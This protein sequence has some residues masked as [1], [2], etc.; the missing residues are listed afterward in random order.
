MC[1]V[2]QIGRSGT[3]A[4][5]GVGARD[6]GM[7]LSKPDAV[8]QL[9]DRSSSKRRAAAKALRL[10]RDPSASSALMAAL[11]SEVRD[12]RTWETQ[13]Q[14]VMALGESGYVPARDWLVEF[15]SSLGDPFM[16]A[17]GIGD[18]VVRLSILAGTTEDAL[19]WAMGSGRW[20]ILD[21]ALRALAMTRTVPTA[22][23][24]D[25][26]LAHLATLNAE[27]GL[28]FWAAVGA[29][30]WPGDAARHVLAEWA[31]LSRQDVT[32]AAQISLSGGYRKR[33]PL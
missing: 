30:D 33:H 13:Y 9:G 11:E 29:V 22:E 1:S 8:L 26:I 25:R 14:M 21:G 10:L 24:V 20:S 31:A 15:A 18:A 2:V 27:D 12:A 32:E 23:T 17:V 4:C 16:L 28:R 5:E 7:A 6:C 3:G 19:R